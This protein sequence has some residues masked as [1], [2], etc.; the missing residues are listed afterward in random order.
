MVKVE[1][2]GETRE[3][4]ASGTIREVMAALG[5]HVDDYV[6]LL[7]GA[8]VTEHEPFSPGDTVKFVRVWSGG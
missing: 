6:A 5:L 2:D 1:L 7:N 8:V 4:E 3:V